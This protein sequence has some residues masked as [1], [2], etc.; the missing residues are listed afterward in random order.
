MKK[1]EI[2]TILAVLGLD[3]L[4]K[5]LTSTLIPYGDAVTVIPNFFWLTYVTNTG[6]AW[7]LLSDAPWF[8]T[9]LGSIA[10]VVILTLLIKAKPNV[11]WYRYALVFLFAGAFGNVIDRLL[12]GHVRDFLAFNL[13][14]YPFP[15]F[16]V[17]DIALN[18]G[19]A[20]MLLDAVMDEMRKKK[21]A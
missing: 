4:T 16:N 10:S 15:V 6:A 17:A 19:V 13:F 7:S 8:F 2:F 9:V 20:C 21:H 3:A 18:V 11:P 14:G 1:M 12:Y 5:T